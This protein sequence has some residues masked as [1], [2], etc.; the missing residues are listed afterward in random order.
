MDVTKLK[1]AIA[2]AQTETQAAVQQ[3]AK[4]AEK[5]PIEVN[6]IAGLVKVNKALAKAQEAAAAAQEKSTPKPKEEKD[7]KKNAKK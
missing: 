3:A 1:A 6:A 2:A 5:T 7:D 4:L